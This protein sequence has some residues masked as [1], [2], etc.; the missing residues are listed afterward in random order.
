MFCKNCGKEIKGEDSFCKFCG[1][2]INKKEEK[3]SVTSKDKIILEEKNSIIKVVSMII[4]IIVIIYTFSLGIDCPEMFYLTPIVG[5]LALL[6]VWW[7]KYTFVKYVGVCKNCGKEIKLNDKKLICKDCDIKYD[8]TKNENIKI[9]K[10]LKYGNIAI[11]LVSI[12]CLILPSLIPNS[13]NETNTP[14]NFNETKYNISYT[15]NKIGIIKSNDIQEYYDD[16]NNLIGLNSKKIDNVEFKYLYDIHNRVTKIFTDKDKSY[17]MIS[18]LGNTKTL[19]EVKIYI[20]K[21][22]EYSYNYIY[23]DGSNYPVITEYFKSEYNRNNEFMGQVSFEEQ[24]KDSKKY[25]LAIETDGSNIKNKILY[26]KSDKDKENIF[27]I[28]GVLPDS[29][30]I[31]T[32]NTCYGNNFMINKG[33][34]TSGFNPIYTVNFG[35]IIKLYNSNSGTK[36]YLYDNKGNILCQKDNY[37]NLYYKYSYLSDNVCTINSLMEDLYEKEYYEQKGK[38]YFSNKEIQK[39]EMTNEEKIT[40]EE[41]NKNINEY[42][43]YCEENKVNLDGLKF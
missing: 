9:K 23:A 28:L 22:G 5:I 25:V 15:K 29:S 13:I 20:S 35:K 32:F 2:T 10:F 38:I 36:E 27:S 43:K 34:I 18:Y 1:Q 24:E 3:D 37:S 11:I 14:N 8:Y 31:N 30:Y 4:S 12:L 17:I 26:E 40:F 42:K 6:F 39:V 41:Y 16:S 21:L 19:K 7:I 33:Q